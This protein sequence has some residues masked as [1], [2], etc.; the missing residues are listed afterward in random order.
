MKFSMFHTDK[1][2][3]YVTSFFLHAA[4][5][6]FGSFVFVTPVEYAVEVGSGGVE[7]N[8]IAA[9]AEIIPEHQPV[10][11]SPPPPV[12]E[13]ELPLPEPEPE[14]KI[15]EE[16]TPPPSPEDIPL[17]QPKIKEQ[18][19]PAPPVQEVKT[20]SPQ[21]QPEIKEEKKLVQTAVNPEVKGDGS[22]SVPG[23][24]ETT[25]SSAGGAITEAKPNYLRNP[26]PS[27]PYEAREKGWEGVVILR[28]SVDKRGYPKKIEKEQSSGYEV[29]DLSALKAI[30]SWRFR[31]A[32]LGSLPVESTVLVPVRFQIEKPKNAR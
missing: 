1:F 31:P 16:I 3:G 11:Q 26:A 5:F 8:L 19:L 7:V 24:S 23:K 30:K 25:F 21:I 2:I 15:E 18:P 28:V 27:Y 6:A 13:K 32:Q 20:S 14:P 17:P 10:V 22:S 4:S 29:L 9:P 12:Q